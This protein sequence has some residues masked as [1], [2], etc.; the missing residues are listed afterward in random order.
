MS[1]KYWYMLRSKRDKL[2]AETDKTQLPDFPVDTKL[3]GQYKEYRQ[4]LRHLPKMYNDETVKSAK[5]KSFEDWIEFRRNGE[6]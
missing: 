1:D 3:R 2:L 6:Y 4:Y 5:V